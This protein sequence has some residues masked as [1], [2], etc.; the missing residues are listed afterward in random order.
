[1]TKPNLSRSENEVVIAM[2]KSGRTLKDV[3]AKFDVSASAVHNILKRNNV[4]SSEGGAKVRSIK[5][6]KMAREASERRCLERYGCKKSELEK[7]NLS[8]GLKAHQKLI[9]F[10]VKG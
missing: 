1:M 8:S 7:L 9:W 4:T 6:E 3:G 10:G 2:Y 5:F